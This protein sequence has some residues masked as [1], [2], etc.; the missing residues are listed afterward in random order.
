MQAG[1]HCNIFGLHEVNR[2]IEVTVDFIAAEFTV[3][4]PLRQRKIL[5][6]IT[7]A[8]THLAGW[9]EG[10]C[11]PELNSILPASV[12]ELLFE[13]VKPLIGSCST[14]MP[15]SHHA[16]DMELFNGD[17]G[18]PGFHQHAHH[19]SM[20]SIPHAFQPCT[21]F[22][23]PQ[24]ILCHV[25]PSSSSRFFTSLFSGFEFSGERPLSSFQGLLHS[26]HSGRFVD[27]LEWMAFTGHHKILQAQI[28][29]DSI[30]V[31]GVRHRKISFFHHF[32]D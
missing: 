13:T 23:H 19:P 20:I 22:L 16:F 15:V 31:S 27:I 32:I 6:R 26:F 28:H 2:C 12:Q 24:D 21:E 9:I 10:V 8:R 1:Q 11:F 30:R 5:L 25:T 7:T 29:A 18:W 14:P 17:I 4:D 3:E